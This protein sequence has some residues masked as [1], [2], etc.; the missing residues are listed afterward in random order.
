MSVLAAISGST[1][2][3][4]LLRLV[5]I[6]LVLVSP[7]GLVV[8]RRNRRAR[9]PEPTESTMA[10]KPDH[11]PLDLTIVLDRIGAGAEAGEWPVEFEI[12]PD[13][14]VGRQRL[15]IDVMDALVA[16]SASRAR[17]PLAPLDGDGA[18]RR[19]WRVG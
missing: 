19:R 13:T 15:P 4:T 16:D 12:T 14:H 7:Y 9:R 2:P 3:A 5:L 6:A 10:P 1:G 11:D 8:Y 17:A 18:D